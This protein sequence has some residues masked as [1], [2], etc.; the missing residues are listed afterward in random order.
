MTTATDAR[1]NE[2][3]SERMNESRKDRTNERRKERTHNWMNAR[4]NKKITNEWTNWWIKE[5]RKK[6]TDGQAQR[7][8]GHL[9]KAQ[10]S[11]YINYVLQS[12][13]WIIVLPFVWI[14]SMKLCAILALGFLVLRTTGSHARGGGAGNAVGHWF[15]LGNVIPRLHCHLYFSRTFALSA[16]SLTNCAVISPPGKI[17]EIVVHISWPRHG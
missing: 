7:M 1:M 12:A 16:T 3:M 14:Q 2:W 9:N 6:R 17:M 5:G 13:K 10:L 11:K 15:V 4:T 8:N